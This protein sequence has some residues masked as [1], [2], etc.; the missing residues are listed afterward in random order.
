MEF[1]IKATERERRGSTCH[2]CWWVAQCDPS[3]YDRAYNCSCLTWPDSYSFTSCSCTCLHSFTFSVSVSAPTPTLS[4]VNPLVW[5]VVWTSWLTGCFLEQESA[6][7]L[8]DTQD[9]M[10]TGYGQAA[11]CLGI[12]TQLFE[13]AGIS[14]GPSS[15]QTQQLFF[16]I[17]GNSCPSSCPWGRE[18]NKRFFKY[19]VNGLHMC[20]VS[21]EYWFLDLMCHNVI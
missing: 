20:C 8:T 2:H 1:G 6:C 3:Q 14:L 21:V 10:K 11:G 13:I 19:G 18:V 5:S 15:G 4:G 17:F 12:F 9:C 16:W 7:C